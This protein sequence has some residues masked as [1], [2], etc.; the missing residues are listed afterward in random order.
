MDKTI[1]ICSVEDCP[2]CGEDGQCKKD[3]IYLNRSG[4]CEEN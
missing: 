2:D 3:I 1:V 4:T